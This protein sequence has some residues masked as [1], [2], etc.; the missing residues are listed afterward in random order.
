VKPNAILDGYEGFGPGRLDAI[1]RVSAQ[2]LFAFLT[3]A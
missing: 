1:N 2:T 3:D